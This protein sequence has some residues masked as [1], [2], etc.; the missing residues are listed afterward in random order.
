MATITIHIPDE[1]ACYFES[2]E[3]IQRTIYEDFVIEQR[4][5]GTISLGEAARLLDIT[6]TDF[7]ALLG[8]KGLSFINATTDELQE[9]YQQFTDVIESARK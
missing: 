5:S 6:Y 4:Q 3:D 8:Q 2:E 7:F 9:S 1:L